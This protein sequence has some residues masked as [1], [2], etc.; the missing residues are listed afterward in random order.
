[1]ATYKAKCSQKKG[2]GGEGQ[3]LAERRQ[4]GLR[5]TMG[6]SYR[7]P[8]LQCS[9]MVT[10]IARVSVKCHRSYPSPPLLRQ[11]RFGSVFTPKSNSTSL[12]F[13]SLIPSTIVRSCVTSAFSSSGQMFNF[14]PD[15]ISSYPLDFEH[16]PPPSHPTTQPLSDRNRGFS[17]RIPRR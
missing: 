16:W 3:N 6:Q 7:P 10:N 11:I 9:R 1:L 14:D 12:I 13:R 2:K 17:V 15:T 4:S 5:G 8:I